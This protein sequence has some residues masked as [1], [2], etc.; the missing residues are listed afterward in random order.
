MLQKCAEGI[1]TLVE[2]LAN[3]KYEQETFLRLFLY[4][5]LHVSNAFLYQYAYDFIL[6]WDQQ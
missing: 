5:L 2:V 1:N 6:T 3:F 4:W